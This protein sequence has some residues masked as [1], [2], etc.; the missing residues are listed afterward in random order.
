MCA[1]YK[2]TE[3]GA[4]QAQVRRRLAPDAQNAARRQQLTHID[5]IIACV[6][7][8]LASALRCEPHGEAA[9]QTERCNVNNINCFMQ[10][11]VIA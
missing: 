1:R 11:G 2:I 8:R 4:G 3:K 9:K 6:C 7:C 10:A 5:G